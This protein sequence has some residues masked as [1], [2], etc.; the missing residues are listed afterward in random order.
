LL[1]P[2]LVSIDSLSWT[3]RHKT[4]K[5]CI[6]KVDSARP[7]VR[8]G[9]RARDDQNTP[10][11]NM[12]QAPALGKASI[13]EY[14]GSFG[15]EKHPWLPSS[16]LSGARRGDKPASIVRGCHRP[17]GVRVTQREEGLWVS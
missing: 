6:W 8:L 16:Y 9:A 7:E 4:V 1:L 15:I 12:S 11:H 3:H 5:V 2:Q 13:R 10:A 17:F 14:H